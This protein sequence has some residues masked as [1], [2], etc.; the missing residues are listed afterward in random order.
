M[1]KR[2]IA[3]LRGYASQRMI[4]GSATLRRSLFAVRS[5]AEPWNEK[6]AEPWN[7]VISAESLHDFRY[8]AAAGFHP[9]L[10]ATANIVT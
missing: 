6:T 4:C 5:T 7:E 3:L 1:H 8:V 2:T 9:R 10:H